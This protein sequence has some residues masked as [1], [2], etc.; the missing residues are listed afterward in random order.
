MQY[1]TCSIYNILT[2]GYKNLSHK[3]GHN[4]SHYDFLSLNLLNAENIW[5]SLIMVSLPFPE[6][7][8]H[9]RKL[10][11]KAGKD[12]KDNHSL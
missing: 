9:T 12:F 2:L 4:P 6:K 11:F 3:L 7:H 8:W 1:L 5:F 10:N